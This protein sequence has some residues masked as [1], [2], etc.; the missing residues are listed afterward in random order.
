[1]DTIELEKFS[2]PFLRAGT[3]PYSNQAPDQEPLSI[4]EEELD[5]IVSASNKLQPLITEAMHT[6]TYR[7]N[8]NLHLSK[9][10]PG[11]LNVRHQGVFP[12]LIKQ[13]VQAVAVKYH[14]E[15]HAGQ[16]WIYAD[17]E[18]VPAE[19]AQTLK[20]EF[21][22]RSAELLGLTDPDT[23]E[24]HPKVC[25]SV[26]FLPRTTRPAVSGQSPEFL[27]ECAGPEDSLTIITTD[28][29]N[30]KGADIM[31]DTTKDAVDVAELQKTQA[32]SMAKIAELEAERADRDAKELS[33]KNEVTELRAAQDRSEV[34]SIEREWMQ[35]RVF[36]N[37][38]F[39]LAPAAREILM[40]RVTGGGIIELADGETQRGQFVKMVNEIIE[41]AGNETLLVQTSLEGVTPNEKPGTKHEQKTVTNRVKELMGE[42]MEEPDAY[43]QA[44]DEGC[45][46]IMEVA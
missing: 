38:S 32:A 26:A 14:K 28:P 5:D 39:I 41:M 43:A 1:M 10:V 15:E 8:E 19:I 3:F 27:V 31:A 24:H 46:D 21:P 18:N 36:G 34:T 23:G 22:L 35:P 30:G 40:P 29:G 13:G 37:R 45:E 20:A 12:E 9:P 17:F 25:R 11:A 44:V 4:T 42:G 2:V 33:L 7:G 16:P 6:G